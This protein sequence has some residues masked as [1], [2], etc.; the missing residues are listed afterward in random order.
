MFG[1]GGSAKAASCQKR[2][3]LRRL[4]SSFHC[5]ISKKPPFEEKDV[6]K[7]DEGGCA[8]AGCVRESHLLTLALRMR[9]LRDVSEL[10]RLPSLIKSLFL[11]GIQRMPSGHWKKKENVIAALDNVEARLGIQKV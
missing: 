2:Y 10:I 9:C 1:R 7:S 4:P 5:W 8:Q 3:R 6:K 11:E